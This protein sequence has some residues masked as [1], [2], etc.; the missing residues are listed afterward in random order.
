VTAKT[1]TSRRRDAPTPLGLP[2]RFGRGGNHPIGDDPWP[3]RSRPRYGVGACARGSR[4]RVAW[5][6]PCRAVA[7]VL[8]PDATVLSAGGGEGGSDP[9]QSHREAQIFHPPY[10]FRGPRPEINSAPDEVEYGE[11]FSVQISAE[12]VSSVSW[13]R[14]SSVTHAFNQNQ[15][16]NFLKYTFKSNR[17]KI[18]APDRPEVCTPGHYMLFVLSNAGVPSRAHILRI[19]TLA[20]IKRRRVR[21]DIVGLFNRQLF[22]RDQAILTESTGTL[23]TIGLTSRCPYGLGAC[24]G[25]RDSR[26]LASL[27]NS[28]AGCHGF[29][30][31]PTV[32]H[33]LWTWFL[34][35]AVPS[36]QT[37]SDPGEP[38]E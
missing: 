6:P 15:R 1:P 38:G 2:K 10:L 21:Q 29:K 5:A 19:G 27:C 14:L 31:V 34:I 7:S 9:N 30:P 25:L 11:E 17:L 33:R 3:C 23:V 36:S 24:W 12:N 20:P 37:C 22:D 4:R 32:S 8:L 18:T 28:I 35:I 16:I 26:I 13:I